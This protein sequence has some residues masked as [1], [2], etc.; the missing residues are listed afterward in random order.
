ASRY[1]KLDHPYLV[2]INALSTHHKELAVIDALIGT[3]YAQ[4]SKGPDGEEIIECPRK[5]D[6]I[7]YGPPDGQAQNTRLDEGRSLEFRQ[8]DRPTHTQSVGRTAAPPARARYRC[9]G[10]R[11]TSGPLHFDHPAHFSQHVVVRLHLH[12]VGRICSDA[13][14]LLFCH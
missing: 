4:V 7:W 11:R 14:H 5:P 3:E 13:L 2:A 12:I 10:R 1:G 6:G 8:Q 9:A